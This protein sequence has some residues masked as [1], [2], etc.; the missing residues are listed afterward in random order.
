MPFRG[1]DY[2]ARLKR[3]AAARTPSAWFA[4]HELDPVQRFD[5]WNESMTVFL[6]TSLSRLDNA[7]AFN[8]E[9]ESYLLDDIIFS[10]AQANH[11]KFDRPAAKI[12]HDGLQHYMIQLFLDGH[13]EMNVGRR[14]VRNRPGQVVGFDLGEV[15]DSFN[16]DFDVFS[17]IIPRPRLAPLLARPDSLQGVMPS[18]DDGPGFLLSGYLQTLYYA[19]PMLTPPEA[20][21]A[22]RAMLE[23]MAAAFNKEI[24]G[25]RTETSIA[26]QSLLLRAQLFIRENLGGSLTSDQ[27]AAGV[28]VSRSLLYQLFEPFGG[29]AGYVRE[30]RLRKCFAEIVSPRH[31]ASQISE[32]GYRWG[33][34][35]PAVFTRAFRRRY[36]RSPSEAREMARVYARRDRRTF[37]PRAGNRLHEEWIVALA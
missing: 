12:A 11:Q 8:G 20:S 29:V 21:T 23:L 26:Q 17:I 28:G 18:L 35:D 33:F 6:D 13:A 27:I 3:N 25:P 36:G 14:V 4:T 16:S 5:A 37:D 7:V 15:M 34:S 1:L 22:V 32:I 9:I 30:L 19:A 31:A 2:A 24:V 10:R